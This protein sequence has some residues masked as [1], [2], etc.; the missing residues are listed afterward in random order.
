MG[1]R[2]FWRW[3]GEDR[4]V[5]FSDKEDCGFVLVGFGFF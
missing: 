5:G 2:G 4:F 3:S 1:I